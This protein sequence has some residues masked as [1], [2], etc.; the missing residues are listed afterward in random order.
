M[1]LLAACSAA[2]SPFVIPPLSAT[3]Q[4]SDAGGVQMRLVAAQS[5]NASQNAGLT[6]GGTARTTTAQSA[7]TFSLT[8]ETRTETFA[9]TASSGLRA[10]STGTGGG[11]SF[12]VLDPRVNLRYN[13][14]G[15]ASS[16]TVA[17]SATRSDIA[18]IR[19][20]SDFFDP[21]TGVLTLPQDFDDLTGTGTRTA[22]SF[23]GSLS[24]R[25]DAPFG[26][27]LGVQ[28]SDLSYQN[29]T[30]ANLN[31]SRSITTSVTGRFNIT[32]V[33]AARAGL[34]YRIGEEVGSARTEQLNL[35]GSLTI[36]QPDG[37]YGLS[38]GATD[39]QNGLDRVSASLSRSYQLSEDVSMSGSI[40]L[41]R[42]AAGD[43]DT[44]GSLGLNYAY[45]LGTISA[46]LNR[47]VSTDTDGTED[48]VTSLSLGATRA[49][50]PNSGIS[51]SASY[52]QTEDT[53]TG[54]S[55]TLSSIGA[56]YSHSL[57]EDWALSAGISVSTRD[58]TGAA[59]ANASELS[60][61]LTRSFDFRR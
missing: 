60:L 50:T 3:A 41:V 61:G 56:S 43:I 34:S 57:T 28:V 53:G 2:I 26:V 27:T 33:M 44:S 31:D 55:T 32:P 22:L 9:L 23:S 51:L 54:V 4:D 46:G 40:G 35:S 59:R 36:D 13:R 48:L 11:A 6:P 12:G 7:L 39:V 52:A 42:T 38:V 37:S 30:A 25:D 14:E 16:L 58:S 47:G 18:Y 24:L 19:P 20:L 1:A 49:L 45:P 29:V 21:D 8:D 15:A 17:A 5:L 10:S